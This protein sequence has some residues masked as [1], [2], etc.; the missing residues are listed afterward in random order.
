MIEAIERAR[1]EQA[2]HDPLIDIFR[3]AY[4]KIGKIGELPVFVALVNHRFDRFNAD[5]AKRA[6]PDSE[7]V[8]LYG[9]YRT[10]TI[11]IRL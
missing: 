6:E 5:T 8:A 10:G 4:G 11:D 2:F 3:A 9:E 1:V 7:S